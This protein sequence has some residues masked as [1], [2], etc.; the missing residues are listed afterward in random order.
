VSTTMSSIRPLALL[1]WVVLATS[2]LMAVVLASPQEARAA[3]Y[4]VTNT[5]VSGTGSLRQAIIDANANAEA[6]TI[7]FDL[8][9]SSPTITVASGPPYVPLPNITA[10]GGALTIDGGI[11]GVTVSNGDVGIG[12]VFVVDK[13]AQL[14]INR[15]TVTKGAGCLPELCDNGAVPQGGGIYNAGTLEV[16]YSTI[17]DSLTYK[18][19]GGIYN[20][21]TLVL[22]SSTISN[23]IDNSEYEGPSSTFGGGGINSATGSTLTVSNSTITGNSAAYAGGAIQSDAAGAKVWNT[24]IAYNSSKDHAAGLG[25][26]QHNITLWNTLLA[27]NN[28]E[29]SSG[30]GV[31]NCWPYLR[32]INGGNNL[33]S[34]ASCH[35]GSANHSISNTDPGLDELPKNNGGPTQTLAVQSGSPAINHGNNAFAVDPFGTVNPGGDPLAYDQRGASFARFVGPAVDIGAFEV[36]GLLGGEPP[37]AGEPEDKQACKKGGYEEFGFKNQ[38]LCIKAVNHAS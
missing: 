22:F 25:L 11:S 38:G 37:P 24:T 6:D 23:N 10:A 31:S 20:A 3:T 19:G 14:T 29:N 13:G 28:N 32:V 36:Q 33:D 30:I 26:F 16:K 1:F 15:L 8:A 2:V 27:D 5:D 34:S 4:T 21:G 9:G 35:F 18:G 17:S 12:Q 7:D